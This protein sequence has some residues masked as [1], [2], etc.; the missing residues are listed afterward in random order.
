MKKHQT[1]SEREETSTLAPQTFN[2]VKV[3]K[4]CRN[5]L[6]MWNR[7]S[8]CKLDKRISDIFTQIGG[9][10][11]GVCH[12]RCVRERK[13]E[14]KRTGNSL[15]GRDDVTSASSEDWLNIVLYAIFTQETSL[16]VKLLLDKKTRIHRIYMSSRSGI[17]L[18][19][20]M[21]DLKNIFKT[22]RK[23][24]SH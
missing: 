6:G 7:T 9:F 1:N 3:W 12:C 8:H 10:P 20:R 15:A 14:K 23:I 2:A 4:V 16:N 22:Q 21:C 11:E 13:K 19:S 5:V 24:N 17:C 18:I